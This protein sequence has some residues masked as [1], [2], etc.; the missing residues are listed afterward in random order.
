MS[1]R[2]SL[3][4]SSGSKRARTLPS[5]LEQ[6]SQGGTLQAAARES[7]GQ[8]LHSPGRVQDDLVG[9]EINLLG[10][11]TRALRRGDAGAADLADDLAGTGHEPLGN[12][13][14]IGLVEADHLEPDLR[15]GLRVLAA[16]GPWRRRRRPPGMLISSV[17]SL[18]GPKVRSTSCRRRC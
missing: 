16:R 17:G 1:L 18:Q 10:F 15:V 8:G 4:R 3:F 5:G 2:T 11:R 7:R 13:H 9:V 12:R 6:E 14:A